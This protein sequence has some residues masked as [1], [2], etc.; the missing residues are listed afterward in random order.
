MAITNKYDQTIAD[1]QA[2]KNEMIRE[3]WI[4]KAN[5]EDLTNK[6]KAVEQKLI[7]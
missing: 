4:Y 7:L 2:E 5:I 3:V 6:F 1:L